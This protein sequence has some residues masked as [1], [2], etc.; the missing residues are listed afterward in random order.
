MTYQGLDFEADLVECYKSIRV[1]MS[2][3]YPPSDFG[4]EK[5]PLENT[6]NMSKEELLCYKR[7]IERVEKLNKDGYNRVKSEDKGIAIWLQDRY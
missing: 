6:E 7:R 1:L 2:Q 3:M 4:V 5:V